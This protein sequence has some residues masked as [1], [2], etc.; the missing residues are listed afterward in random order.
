MEKI[1]N[2][3]MYLYLIPP[4]D[5]LYFDLLSNIANFCTNFVA[6]GIVFLSFIP[7]NG[8]KSCLAAWLL[9]CGAARYSPFCI[10]AAHTSPI[11]Q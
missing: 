9:G 6:Q 7:I 1:P 4:V 2:K 5:F 10:L 11:I 3:A 8:F